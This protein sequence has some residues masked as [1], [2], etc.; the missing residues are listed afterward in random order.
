MN[1][2]LNKSKVL[3]QISIHIQTCLLSSLTL[4]CTTV[5][6]TIRHVKICTAL[7]SVDNCT[8]YKN[9]NLKII[10]SI[11]VLV[12][13]VNNVCK[14]VFRNKLLRLIKELQIWVI[15]LNV[16]AFLEKS[17]YGRLAP[18]CAIFVG[19]YVFQP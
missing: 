13:N 10:Y 6:H 15:R 17:G 11:E 8:N 4:K 7:S 14:F 3:C 2:V 1:V 18:R 16:Q 12:S 5:G 19:F 9:K